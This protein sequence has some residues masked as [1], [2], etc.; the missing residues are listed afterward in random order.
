MKIL[1]I[2]EIIFCAMNSINI[3]PLAKRRREI[4]KH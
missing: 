4:G 2:L 3:F 1:L